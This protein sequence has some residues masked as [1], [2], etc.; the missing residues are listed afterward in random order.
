MLRVGPWEVGPMVEQLYSSGI[1]RLRGYPHRTIYWL[2]DRRPSLFY[3][4][5][6]VIFRSQLQAAVAAFRPNVII[7]TFHLLSAA[8]AAVVD[9]PVI[10]IVPAGGRVNRMCF[11]GSVRHFV[12][13]DP[14]S[15]K[16]ALTSGV[17]PSRVSVL[18]HVL[19]PP[20]TSIPSQEEARRRLGLPSKLTVLVAAGSVG[21][22]PHLTT[23]VRSLQPERVGVGLLV[24]A[25]R[26]ERLRNELAAYAGESTV[27]IDPT[28]PSLIPYVAAADVVVG[29]AGWLTLTD[30]AAVGRPTLIVDRI[31]G[32]EDENA[33][34]ACLSGLAQ[35]L[36][37]TEA[38][39]RIRHYAADRSTLVRDFTEADAPRR[40]A[41]EH[42]TALAELVSRVVEG[43]Q[44]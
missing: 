5:W 1:A 24:A 9:V 12:F 36:T 3:A 28:E 20:A 44:E 40:V 38:A 33:R 2:M 17:S 14:E 31:R 23:F 16:F 6:T 26:N 11:A 22:G 35:R 19:D 21:Y 30:A 42:E 7:S 43:S 41:P 29:K 10:S 34:A 8:L 4:P 39:I 27:F 13:C 15:A 37:P 18:P 32:Q 25:G